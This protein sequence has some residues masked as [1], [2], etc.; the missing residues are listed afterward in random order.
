MNDIKSDI[1]IETTKCCWFTSSISTKIGLN[2]MII[3]IIGDKM[4]L[5]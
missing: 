2:N 3:V 5:P 1:Q 4:K